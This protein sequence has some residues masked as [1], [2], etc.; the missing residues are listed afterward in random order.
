MHQRISGLLLLF[1]YSTSPASQKT[2]IY[3]DEATHPDIAGVVKNPSV[4]S[5]GTV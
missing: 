1:N 3:N 2:E 5:Q 4:N